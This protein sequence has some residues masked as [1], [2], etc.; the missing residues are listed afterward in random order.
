[1]QVKNRVMDTQDPIGALAITG[2][3]AAGVLL[4]IVVICIAARRGSLTL[5][6]VIGLRVPALMR[7]ETSWQA[8]H[9]AA[10][11]PAV[12]TLVVALAFD[13]IGIASFPAYWG[14]VAT[15]VAGLI[16]IVVRASRAAKLS[17]TE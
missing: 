17:S 10:L 2:W 14:A 6:T 12:T 1:M 11:W 15:L 7:D 9:A 3:I 16:W 4:L 5:N 13:L 8:G